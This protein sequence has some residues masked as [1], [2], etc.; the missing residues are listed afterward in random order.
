MTPP[1]RQLD[2]LDQRLAAYLDERSENWRPTD[3][4]KIEV[5]TTLVVKVQYL[6][7]ELEDVKAGIRDGARSGFE[8]LSFV[9]NLII[10]LGMLVVTLLLLFKH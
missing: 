7:K 2:E 4:Q 8:K 9:L 5:L 10:A 3:S 6:Q 1:R